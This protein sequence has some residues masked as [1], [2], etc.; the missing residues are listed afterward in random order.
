MSPGYEPTPGHASMLASQHMSCFPFGLSVL[1]LQ[2]KEWYICLRCRRAVGSHD[3]KMGG[4]PSIIWDQCTWPMCLLAPQ[5]R[6]WEGA[7]CAGESSGRALG[8]NPV[9]EWG[10]NN[11]ARGGVELKCNCNWGLWLFHGEFWTWDGPSDW[12]WWSHGSVPH[13]QLSREEVWPLWGPRSA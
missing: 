1:G 10:E 6:C 9:I 5:K 4:N 2:W 12:S 7:L 11:R 8:E 3:R 13:V